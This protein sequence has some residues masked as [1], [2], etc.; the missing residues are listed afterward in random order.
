MN[1]WL[2]LFLLLTC[3]LSACAP[4]PDQYTDLE[5][6]VVNPAPAQSILIQV[7]YG[8]VTILKSDDE[9]VTVEGK[10]LFADELEYLIDSSDKQMLIKIFAH[11]ASSSTLPLQVIVRLPEQMQVRVETDEADVVAQGLH[12]LL[13]VASTSGDITMREMAGGMTLRSNRGDITV[14]ESTGTVSIVGN[15]G[16]LTAQNV[17][18]DVSMSTIMGNITYGGLVQGADTVHLETDHGAVSV[19]LSADSALTLQVRST[20]GAVTCLLPDVSSTTR[21]CDGEIHAGGGSLS[22]RTVSGAVTLQLIP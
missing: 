15:Y 14:Q 9:R 10:V 2:S 7:D 1:R 12:G 5:T 19:D 16:G 22:I 18:G 21:T 13:E 11:R 3:L 6:R 4:A 20:S 8:E 17:R